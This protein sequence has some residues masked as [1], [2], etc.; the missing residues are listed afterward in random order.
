V[1]LATPASPFS[2]RHQHLIS[3]LRRRTVKEEDAWK[4]ATA[5][6]RDHGGGGGGTKEMS[7]RCTARSHFMPSDSSVSLQPLVPPPARRSRRMRCHPLAAP[8]A[9]AASCLWP[10]MSYMEWMGDFFLGFHSG[11]MALRCSA[12]RRMA[13]EA[14]RPRRRERVSWQRRRER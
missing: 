6:S 3:P 11:C 13:I 9:C 14:A 10:V 8:G 7:S 12:G 4:E 2:S 5:G 1:L